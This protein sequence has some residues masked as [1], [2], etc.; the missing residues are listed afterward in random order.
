MGPVPRS[1]A[2]PGAGPGLDLGPWS[3]FLDR[4]GRGTPHLL[5]K[6]L[7]SSRPH[8]SLLINQNPSPLQHKSSNQGIIGTR[9]VT[10]RQKLVVGLGKPIT[11]NNGVPFSNPAYLFAC[12]AAYFWH[13]LMISSKFLLLLVLRMIAW[14]H[15]LRDRES[16]RNSCKV[17]NKT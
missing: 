2:V 13:I 9:T 15:R 12:I 4:F 6:S 14:I 10:V 5:P 3:R 7:S 8:T 11:T 1:G 17:F 16:I